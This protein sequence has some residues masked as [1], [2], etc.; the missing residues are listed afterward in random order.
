V[1][2]LRLLGRYKRYY[3]SREFGT[4]ILSGRHLLQLVSFRQACGFVPGLIH[5]DRHGVASGILRRDYKGRRPDRL[6]KRIDPGVVLLVADLRGHE[7][8]A[9]EELEQWRR[10]T[11]NAR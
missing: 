10:T 6:V 1:A 9:V 2:E 8:Q 3:V 7:H 5:S 11:R 4:P